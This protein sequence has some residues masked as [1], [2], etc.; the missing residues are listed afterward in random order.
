MSDISDITD[1]ASI[2]ESMWTEHAI[3]QAHYEASLV[4]TTTHTHCQ[5]CGDPTE[6]GK[7]FCT[8]G[9]DSC[10]TDSNRRDEII[11]KGVGR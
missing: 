4:D 9:P 7:K 3:R 2:V 8:Y 6:D 11:R 1:E 10:A 5:W